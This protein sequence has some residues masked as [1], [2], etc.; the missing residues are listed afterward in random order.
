MR[1]CGGASAISPRIPRPWQD[2]PDL[3]IQAARRN[4]ELVEAV[5]RLV[6]A[7]AFVT[8]NPEGFERIETAAR[9]ARN[10]SCPGR[11]RS[12]N[13]YGTA[14]SHQPSYPWR[15]C[16]PSYVVAVQRRLGEVALSKKGWS[17]FPSVAG[18]RVA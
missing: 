14:G 3:I 18:H 15:S 4:L 5:K 16:Q 13:H 1:S 17:T 11:N 6:D 12:R 9:A 2:R 10:R 7:W 8:C